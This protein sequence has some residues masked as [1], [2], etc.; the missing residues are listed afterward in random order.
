[1]ACSEFAS[2]G[3]RTICPTCGVPVKGH[4]CRLCGATKTINSV[5]GN[6]IWMRNGRIVRAFKDARFAWLEMAKKYQ[7]PYAEWPVAFL[8]EAQRKLREEEE[9]KKAKAKKPA[10]KSKKTLE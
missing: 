3:K 7:I 2:P 6:E 9:V 4:K 8:P 5:S 1:M 10:K